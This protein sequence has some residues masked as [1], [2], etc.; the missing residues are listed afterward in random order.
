MYILV[1]SLLLVDS[2]SLSNAQ[3]KGR[4]LVCLVSFMNVEN[5]K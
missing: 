3:W 1:Y 4:K 2:N 5:K